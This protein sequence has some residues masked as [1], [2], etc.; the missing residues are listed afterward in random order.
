MSQ[1]AIVAKKTTDAETTHAR[2]FLLTFG[3]R[4]HVHN[5]A[6]GRN[7]SRDVPFRAM[8]PQSRPKPNHGRQPSSSSIARQS[9]IASAS[10]SAERLVSHIARVHQNMTLGSSAHAHAD[11]RATFSENMRRAMRKIGMHV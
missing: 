2:D 7:A 3:R 5:P 10:S 8:T 1:G 9:Q 6:A 4:Y 11:H